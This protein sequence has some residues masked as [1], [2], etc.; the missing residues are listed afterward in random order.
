MTPPNLVAVK[1]S[2]VAAIGYADGVLWVQ[3][4]S[5][6][7]YRYEKV[8]PVQHRALMVASS[9][10]RA[11]AGI[12]SDPDSYPVD[13]YEGPITVKETG[14]GGVIRDHTKRS[15]IDDANSCWNKTQDHEPVFVVAA[16]DETAA[17]TIRD[18]IKRNAG[19]NPDKLA[20]AEDCA[21]ACEQYPDQRKVG[22]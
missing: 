5:G 2:N 4:K 17:E 6:S 10:G 9:I 14:R 21:L 16:H 18:W 12:T 20:D 7:S 1:S 3:F 22:R 13:R 8:T 15:N 19:A 11:V